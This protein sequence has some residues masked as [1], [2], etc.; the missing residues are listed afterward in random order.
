MYNPIL[1]TLLK[2]LPYYGQSSGENAS[3]SSGPIQRFSRLTLGG[4]QKFKAV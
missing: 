4:F 3:P 2:M 1:V